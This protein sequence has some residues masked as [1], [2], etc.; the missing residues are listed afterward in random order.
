M[1]QINKLTT[2]NII[3]TLAEK[4]TLA[5]PTYLFEVTNDTS[6]VQLCFICT[7]I[8][9]NK[10]RYNEFNIID[11]LTEYPLVGQ[12]NFPLIGFYKYNIYEQSSTSNLDPLL[13]TNLVE[14]GKLQV[15]NNTN[16]VTEYEG[17]AITFKVYGA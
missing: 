5:N 2:N 12:V 7:D 8:S 14:N 1:I 13:A 15:I 6:D 10:E 9:S 17:D 11:S 4:T 16:N 3:L